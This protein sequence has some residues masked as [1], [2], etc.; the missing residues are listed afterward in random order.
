MGVD[1]KCRDTFG[2]RQ[3]GPRSIS[4][5]PDRDLPLFGLASADHEQHRDLGEGVL[6][7]LVA[8]LLVPEVEFGAEAGGIERGVH[9]PGVAVGVAGDR[10]NNDLAGRQPYAGEVLSI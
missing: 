2:Q 10:G 9:L 8:D 1:S 7:H 4:Q 6:T 3:H 5:S